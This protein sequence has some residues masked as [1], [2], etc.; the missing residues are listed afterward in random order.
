[1]IPHIVYVV[2][3]EE[4]YSFIISSRS[5]Y[6]ETENVI[7]F[8]KKAIK[9]FLKRFADEIQPNSNIAYVKINLVRSP[10]SR[11]EN[12]IFF[13]FESDNKKKRYVL[14]INDN[15]MSA[16]EALGYEHKKFRLTLKGE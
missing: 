15:G 16:L 8:V 12:K 9:K 11:N 4:K 3:S 1:M 10:Y 14:E 5:F 2:P 13:T 7:E 6:Y